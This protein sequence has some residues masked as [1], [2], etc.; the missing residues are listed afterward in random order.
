ME[1][2]LDKIPELTKHVKSSLDLWKQTK[3]LS[4]EASDA[5]KSNA[6]AKADEI[7][8][9]I[10][11]FDDVMNEIH[12]SYISLFRHALKK[13]PVSISNNGICEWWLNSEKVDINSPEIKLKT[14][15]LICELNEL[16]ES[17][18]NHRVRVRSE[19]NELVGLVNDKFVNLY[20]VAIIL[21]FVQP[22][23][24]AEKGV[25]HLITNHDLLDEREYGDNT[26][27]DNILRTPSKFVASMG[28]ETS[29]PELR[30]TIESKIEILQRAFISVDSLRAKVELKN[31][32]GNQ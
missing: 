4:K 17:N 30:Q 7:K 28:P 31:P 11:S 19:A 18:W 9:R 15:E 13:L 2:W 10:K 6:N 8:N 26:K 32:V 16:R 14:Y 5:L 21:Y 12:Q 29:I 22:E 23:E 27:V 24:L 25:R 3:L 1:D 20:L